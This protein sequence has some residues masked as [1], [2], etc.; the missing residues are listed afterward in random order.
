LSPHPFGLTFGSN[1]FNNNLFQILGRP[2][3]LPTNASRGS[4]TAID[5]EENLEEMES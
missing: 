4:I 3:T 2:I 1:T 5:E